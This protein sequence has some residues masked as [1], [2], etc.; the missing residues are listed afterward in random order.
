MEETA[1]G[2]ALNFVA[3]FVFPS[4]TTLKLGRAMLFILSHKLLRADHKYFITDF[5]CR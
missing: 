5:Y 4:P 3:T 1:V 2:A